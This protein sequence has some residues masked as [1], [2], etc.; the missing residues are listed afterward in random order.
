MWQHV[1]VDQLGDWDVAW[2]SDRNFGSGWEQCERR[3]NTGSSSF[4]TRHRKGMTSGPTVATPLWYAIVARPDPEVGRKYMQHSGRPWSMYC[5]R[6]APTCIR[7]SFFDEKLKTYAAVLSA[8]KIE[9]M[10]IRAQIWQG[11]YKRVNECLSPAA[12][13]LPNVTLLPLRSSTPESTKSELAVSDDEL[14]AFLLRSPLPEPASDAKRENFRAV[15]EA[16]SR[17]FRVSTAHTEL[18]CI[19]L[20]PF[21]VLLCRTLSPT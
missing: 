8:P 9:T 4:P 6:R 2:L 12:D 14:D 3:R 16:C 5:I 18:S 15:T 19:A 17:A 10:P 7:I 13:R 20:T 11:L 21:A 1:F